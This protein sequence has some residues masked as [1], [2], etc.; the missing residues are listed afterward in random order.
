MEAMSSSLALCLPL[1]C[2]MFWGNDFALLMRDSS[3]LVSQAL[4]LT[5]NYAVS[6]LR[7]VYRILP[8][9]LFSALLCLQSEF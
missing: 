8:V 1:S 6:L 3:E 7:L 2:I 9:V 5:L 4:L